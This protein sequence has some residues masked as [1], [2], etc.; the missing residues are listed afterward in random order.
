MNQVIVS[1]VAVKVEHKAD[2]GILEAT[3]AAR[4]GNGG[5]SRVRIK[6]LGKLTQALKDVVQEGQAYLAL[7]TLVPR[8]RGDQETVEVLAYNVLPVDGEKASNE[9]GTYL[10]NGVNEV[11]ISGVLAKDP[12]VRAIQFS[13]EEG[14]VLTTARVAV[15]QKDKTAWVNVRAWGEEFS[16]ALGNRKKGDR[17]V[18]RGRFRVH[19]YEKDGQAHYLPQVIVTEVLGTSQR[20]KSEPQAD[21]L[22][23]ELPDDLF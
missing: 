12:E 4:L 8:K 14:D 2:L 22:P 9:R 21:N 3:L 11:L 5:F 18:L 15:S 10:V 1:G 16:E 6:T 17:V 20:T 19:R 23:E 7:G 13:Q